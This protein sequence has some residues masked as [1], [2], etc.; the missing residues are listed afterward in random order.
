MTPYTRPP[1]STDWT[2]GDWPQDGN[3]TAIC[4]ILPQS[5]VSTIGVAN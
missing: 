4:R 2:T 5:A 1:I 3:L